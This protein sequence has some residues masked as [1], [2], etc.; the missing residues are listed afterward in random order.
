MMAAVGARYVD[1]PEMFDPDSSKLPCQSD[2]S[3]KMK[4]VIAVRLTG[5]LQ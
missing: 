4:G 2:H 5:N 1:G 3:I